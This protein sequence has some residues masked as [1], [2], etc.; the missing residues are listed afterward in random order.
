MAS[1]ASMRVLVVEDYES[2]RT[3]VRRC[4]EGM[5]FKDVHTAANPAEAIAA[6]RGG[7]VNLIIS[8]YDMPGANGVE[9]LQAVREDPQL[10]GTKFIMLSGSSDREVVREALAL[11]VDVYLTKPVGPSTLKAT[12]ARLCDAAA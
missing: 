10:Q 9:F 8:D 12:V 6:A 4:L 3:L 1:I 11:G 7:G 5:G 2:M